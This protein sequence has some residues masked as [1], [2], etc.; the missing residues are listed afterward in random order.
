MSRIW[1][2]VR[3]SGISQR[4]GWIDDISLSQVRDRVSARGADVVEVCVADDFREVAPNQFSTVFINRARGILGL[5]ITYQGNVT[6]Y[7]PTAMIA[8]NLSFGRVVEKFLEQHSI[9]RDQFD[10]QA[11][12]RSFTAQQYLLSGGGAQPV[13]LFR[14]STLVEPASAID[15]QMVSNLAGGIANWMLNNLSDDGGLPYR[16][17]PSRGE[18][19]TADNAIR[20]FLATIALARYGKLTQNAE[21]SLAARHNLQFNLSRYFKNLGDGRGAIVESTGAK[22]GAAALAGLAILEC[23]ASEEFGEHLNL[24]AAGV[25]SLA[26]RKLGFR[27]FFFP[28]ERDGQNWNF[29][30]GEA[31]L[32]WAET[33][34]RKTDHAPSTRQFE[35]AALRCRQRHLKNRN[36]AFVPWYVQA[37]VSYIKTT[38]RQETASSVFEFSDWLLPMQQWDDLTADL[39]GRFYNPQRPDFGPPHASSTGVYLEGLADALSLALAVGDQTRA[40]AYERAIVRGIR[41]LCQ[42][43]FRSQ[44]DAYYISKPHRVMGGLRTEVYDN[45][46]RLDSGAHA[47]LAAIKIL[48]LPTH[49]EAELT[50]IKSGSG[51]G[52]IRKLFR[53]SK[54]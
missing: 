30:L 28:A 18:Y 53:R 33:I 35:N 11:E 36:P 17:W 9:S 39:R 50:Q 52:G 4:E 10:T 42:L 3:R 22:L 25:M 1:Y 7:S 14:G 46:V 38:G 8:S 27:T 31:L 26:D 34:R 20:R 5:E 37:C 47:L 48:Q 29:Y 32:F 54:Y 49:R 19:S 44:L 40:V 6:R 24:L 15:E 13:S 45:P 12:V 41:S 43:Q 23:E 2:C 51:S 16:Y 21:F